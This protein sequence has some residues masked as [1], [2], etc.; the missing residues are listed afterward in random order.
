MKRRG[1]TL[2]ELIVV[3]AIIAVLSSIIAP[4]A[5]RAIEKAKVARFCEDYRAAKAGIYAFY[6]DTGTWPCDDDNMGNAL[7]TGGP[8][9]AC[10]AVA[11]YRDRP[12][13]DGPYID[14]LSTPPWNPA[15]WVAVSWFRWRSMG[16]LGSFCYENGL[17][18]PLPLSAMA[19]IENVQD[20]TDKS[21]PNAGKS[22]GLVRS[23][24]SSGYP[25][26]EATFCFWLV[27][28]PE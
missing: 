4:N 16:A 9:G 21:N 28:R 7:I 3:I 10:D 14:K 11:N 25:N 2:I 13:W 18:P 5:F 19:S 12:G 26:Y 1:F 20:G 8:S 23:Q 15:A 24:G 27:I 6:A 17:T 22:T